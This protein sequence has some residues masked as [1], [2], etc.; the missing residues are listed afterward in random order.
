MAVAVGEA[1]DLVL[2]RGA[3]TRPDALDL[4]GEQRRPV[5]RGADDVVGSRVGPGDRAEEL[6]RRPAPASSATWSSRRRPIP[7]APARAQSIVR[8]SSR[9]GVP[10]LSRA[11]GRPSARSCVRQSRRGPL[12]DPAAGAAASC[13]NEAC[14]RERCRSPGRPRR[15]DSSRPSASVRPATRAALKPKRAASPSTISEALL[16]VE[17]AGG[18]PA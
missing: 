14:R 13:R 12:A 16:R 15:R 4:A 8:P 6:G 9:G 18:S 11:S 17:Q 3:V 5:E 10:V 1:V 2:D 7:A